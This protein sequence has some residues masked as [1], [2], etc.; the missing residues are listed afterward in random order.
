MLATLLHNSMAMTGKAACLKSAKTVLPALQVVVWVAEASVEGLVVVG[1]A[2][3]VVSVAVEALV[4]A[5]VDEGDMAVD[6]E[7]HLV[8]ATMPPRLRLLHQIPSLTS[9]PLV[10]NEVN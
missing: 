4:V 8:A 10:E 7:A 9:P 3:E 1:M 6:M 5:S 2:D